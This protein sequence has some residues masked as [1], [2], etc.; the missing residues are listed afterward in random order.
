MKI[1]VITA[2]ND[3]TS[4][5]AVNTAYRADDTPVMS[6]TTTKM[7]NGILNNEDSYAC[8]SAYA[9]LYRSSTLTVA[10]CSLEMS[11]PLSMPCTGKYIP[12]HASNRQKA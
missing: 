2:E 7:F 3:K 12:T 10:R 5:L 8:L 6:A 9:C 4:A 1:P 11:V